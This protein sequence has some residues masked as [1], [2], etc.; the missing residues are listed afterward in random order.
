MKHECVQMS[1]FNEVRRARGGVGHLP[2]GVLDDD[3]DLA[4]LV[5]VEGDD[6]AEELM[7]PSTHV[8]Y[9]CS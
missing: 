1:A 5:Y 3:V 2:S 4:T 8:L 7:A 6:G 9:S